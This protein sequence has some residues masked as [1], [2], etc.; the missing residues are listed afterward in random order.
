MFHKILCCILLLCISTSALAD[1]PKSIVKTYNS[2][3][4]S[5]LDFLSHVNEEDRSFI[6]FLTTFTVPTS[7]KVRIQDQANPSELKNISLR[8]AMEP[9][10]NFTVHS[11]S[12]GTIFKRIVRISD[13]LYCLDIRDYDWTQEALEKVSLADPY[14]KEPY[15]DH[16]LITTLR[17]E[18]GNNILRA[19]W[20]VAHTLDTAKQFDAGREPLYYELLYAKTGV[21]KTL[22][23]FQDKWGIDVN[24]SIKNKTAKGTIVDTGKSIVALHNRQLFRIRTDSGY[25]WET[26]DVKNAEGDRDF[27]ENLVPFLRK[28]GFDAGEIITNN[29]LGLQVYLLTDAKGNRIEFADNAIARDSNKGMDARVVTARSC[30]MCHAQGI[31]NAG[32]ALKDLLESGVQLHYNQKEDLLDTASFFLDDLNESIKEDQAIFTRA[33]KK[34]TGYPPA[35]IVLMY[36][37][38]VDW[39]E[40]PITFDQS[41]LELGAT[42]EDIILK[43]SPTTR[44]HTGHLIKG[45]TISRQTWEEPNRGAFIEAMLL[46]YD[47]SGQQKLLQVPVNNKKSKIEA[48]PM[49]YITIEEA[50][51]RLGKN[52]VL[53]DD[54]N[55]IFVAPGTE[56]EAENIKD[57]WIG[58][59]ING[60]KGYIHQNYL[61]RVNP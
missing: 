51:L 16:D 57:G 54:G 3:I 49:V 11:L 33:V 28:D 4:I 43:V 21:P 7:I 38:L 9:V 42:A 53:D 15:I 40:S 47:Q 22:K 52:A 45:G 1:E 59:K 41:Q 24:K 6:L 17:L 58:V 5:A 19:D 44:G 23:E 13:T 29:K 14:F 48:K 50:P 25:Y 56:L 31:N 8:E 55:E 20:F 37:K 36:Q 46:I 12:G 61:D 32:N 35:D 30:I 39:Y 10:I 26:Q 60:K 18:A 27:I 34:A 2:E